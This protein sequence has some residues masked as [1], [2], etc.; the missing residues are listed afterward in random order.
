MSKPLFK[1]IS[2]TAISVVA[3]YCFCI[4]V[5]SLKC[6]AEQAAC[7]TEALLTTK[8]YCT[9][10]AFNVCG[11]FNG[12]HS[13]QRPK[14]PSCLQFSQCW[15]LLF[16]P[17]PHQAVTHCSRKW[18][19]LLLDC[20]QEK[21]QFTHNPKQ[22]KQSLHLVRML[23]WKGLS[24]AAPSQSHVRLILMKRITRWKPAFQELELTIVSLTNRVHQP[25]SL[26]KCLQAA[27]EVGMRY[28]QRGIL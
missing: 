13:L 3:Y 15:A 25:I 16:L 24:W 20:L 21:L 12:S 11:A 7:W 23:G 4:H 14:L 28:H 19:P 10:Q 9:N 17:G 8:D 18:H 2:L 1:S 26:F 5:W 27:H 6:F 22:S